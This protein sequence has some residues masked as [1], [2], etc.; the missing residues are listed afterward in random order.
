MAGTDERFA[1]CSNL[2]LRD[3]VLTLEWIR[4]SIERFGGDPGERDDRLVHLP[5]RSPPA[6]DDPTRLYRPEDY[7]FTLTPGSQ[8]IDAGSVLPSVTDGFTGKA[9][10]LGALEWG[11]AVP[12]YGPRPVPSQP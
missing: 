12:A 11:R 9:P 10:D 2:G 4:T 7:D 3:L 1:E 5:Q 8:A 6:K